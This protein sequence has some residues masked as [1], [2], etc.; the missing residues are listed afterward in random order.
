[1]LGKSVTQGSPTLHRMVA[2]HLYPA[3]RGVPWHPSLD[4]VSAAAHPARVQ[5]SP[6]PEDQSYPRAHE[7]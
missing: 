1:M 5:E 4:T 7:G 2:W 6:A 3:P